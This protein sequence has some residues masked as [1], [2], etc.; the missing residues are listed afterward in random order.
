MEIATLAIPYRS[1]TAHFHLY[2][3]GDVH[4]GSAMCDEGHLQA[5]LD[6]IHGDPLAKVFL[7]GDLAEFIAKDDWRFEDETIAEW[8][9]K[10][11]VGACQEK[12]V[13]KLLKPIRKKILGAIQGN[14]ELTL[15]REWDNRVHKHICDELDIPNLGYMALV[16]LLFQWVRK[17][18]VESHALDILL[19]HGYGG[20]RTD[21]ADI[22]RFSE[23]QRDYD[24][25]LVVMGHT[26]KRLAVKNVQHFVTN[27]GQ[28]GT[29]TRLAV[30]SGTFLK[31]VKP[32]YLGYS[33][34]AAM[35]PLATGAAM[36]TYHPDTQDMI[37]N[38]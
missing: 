3:L 19:H 9:D 6:A 26:H 22:N 20:G 29:R 30:R 37:A 32:G 36:V 34:K 12:H 31:T 8:V 11:D 38:V 14:H 4:L 18:T 16:R 25:D 1:R 13:I 2:F 10:G 5:T 17:N 28:L 23:I 15:E 24:V 33:E 27:N 21:G 35:R 7:M